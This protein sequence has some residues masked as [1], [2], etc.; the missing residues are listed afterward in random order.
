M[1]C[2]NSNSVKYRECA[3][4]VK[5]DHRILEMLL[6]PSLMW[7]TVLLPCWNS[8]KVVVS[9]STNTVLPTHDSS[10][11]RCEFIGTVQSSWNSKACPDWVIPL[12]N[13]VCVNFNPCLGPLATF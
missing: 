6:L 3:H 7:A 9:L 11:T 12:V 13:L 8:A 4:S 5:S 1:C 2:N 10:M